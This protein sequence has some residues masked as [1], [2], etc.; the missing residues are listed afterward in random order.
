MSKAMKTVKA[1]LT[2]GFLLADIRRRVDA[3]FIN[4][5]PRKKLTKSATAVLTAAIFVLSFLMTGL[6]IGGGKV[7]A[8]SSRPSTTRRSKL[9]PD[10]EK[11]MVRN[12]HGL[13]RVIV[14]T[15]PFSNSAAFSKLLSK[16]ASMGGFIFRELNSGK[17][18]S[19]QI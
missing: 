15:K 4:F 9:S 11:E 1:P 8:E 10:L 13:V 6:P 5:R 3:S 2:D 14:D 19:A 12:P 7:Q 18:V 16:I 17:S